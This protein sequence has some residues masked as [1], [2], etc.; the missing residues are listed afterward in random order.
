MTACQRP[1]ASLPFLLLLLLLFSCK[2]SEAHRA[3]VQILCGDQAWHSQIEELLLWQSRNWGGQASCNQDHSQ[4]KYQ[5]MSLLLP[6]GEP[7]G[8][9][10]LAAPEA[11]GALQPSTVQFQSLGNSRSIVN[12]PCC[13]KMHGDVPL[14]CLLFS[15]LSFLCFRFSLSDLF[16][17]L[18]TARAS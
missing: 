8:L 3:S 10:L 7:E 15:F 2:L 1:A 11:Q 12:T 5:P 9:H 18:M 14:S 16:A 6:P 13:C 17:F 4:T